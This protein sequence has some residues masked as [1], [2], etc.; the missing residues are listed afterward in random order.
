MERAR[1]DFERIFDLSGELLCVIDPGGLFGRVSSG[2]E[3][4]LG[5]TP[6]ELVGTRCIDLLHADD[7]ER[8]MAET[9][10]LTD[11]GPELIATTPRTPR[12]S[13]RSSR[14]ARHWE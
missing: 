4:Q 6:D 10:G 14:W 8:T 7:L 5:W 9:V 2:W 3:A 11:M 1:H 13:R 12:S